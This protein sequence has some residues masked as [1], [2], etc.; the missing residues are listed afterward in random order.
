MGRYDGGAYGKVLLEGDI[1]TE[2]QKAAGLETRNQAKTF[3]YAYLYGAGD[4]KIGKIVGK[5][6]EHGK[7]LKASFLRKTPA[8]KRLIEAVRESAKR[9][10]LVGLDKR[11]LHVRSSHA[12]LNTLLQS[13]GALVCKYWVLRT[14]ERMEELGY[15]HGFDGDFAFCAY[16]HDEAQ[17]AVRNDEIAAV[18]IEQTA[19][20]MKDAEEVFAFRC[21]LACESKIGTNWYETH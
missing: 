7:K 21:P 4:A 3:I 16:V 10:Y 5:D 9:G 13:A 1:H 12:A 6:A 2:N 8:L 18:L 20:A 15:K 14:A 11:H 17:V 19:L